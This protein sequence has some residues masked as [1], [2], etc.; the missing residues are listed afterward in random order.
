MTEKA[1]AHIFI[2]GRVQGV[3][4]RTI[5][6]KKAVKLNLTGW[7]RNLLD[8]R[9]EM[10][11]EGEKEAIEKLVEEIKQIKQ[12]VFSVIIKNIIID[13]Q[14]NIKEFKNFEIKH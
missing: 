12:G 5:V 10:V 9:V 13:W 11:L 14:K 8:E 4:L 1:R 6:L 2:S 7:I 3:G